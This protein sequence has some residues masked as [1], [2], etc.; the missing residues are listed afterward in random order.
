MSVILPIANISMPTFFKVWAARL[1]S[2]WDFPSVRRITN[3]SASSRAPASGFRFC[4]RTW[5]SARPGEENRWMVSYSQQTLSFLHLYPSLIH[6][7]PQ[8]RC[9]PIGT[10]SPNTALLWSE[11]WSYLWRCCH[12]CSAG[13]SLPPAPG[14]SLH[15]HSDPTLCEDRCCT[16]TALG[17]ARAIDTVRAKVGC[18]RRPVLRRRCWACH[19]RMTQSNESERE[20]ADLAPNSTFSHGGSNL[21][22]VLWS[23]LRSQSY[24]RTN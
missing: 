4:S 8:G 24:S 1:A 19:G 13:S 21:W 18:K 12:P 23:I 20:W 6:F 9:Y 15:K 2:S 22:V 16:G 11:R 3:F 14:P 17:K 10:T 5:V 7:V